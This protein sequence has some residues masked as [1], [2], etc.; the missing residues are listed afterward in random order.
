MGHK[1]YGK[2]MVAREKIPALMGCCT[3]VNLSLTVLVHEIE[4]NEER[5]QQPVNGTNVLTGI[6]LLFLIDLQFSFN[7]NY[8]L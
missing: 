6:Q 5:V 2:D 3:L 8:Y 7:T 1:E 4:K